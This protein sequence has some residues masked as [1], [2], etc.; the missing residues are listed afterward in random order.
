MARSGVITT[1]RQAQ[2]ANRQNTTLLDRLD[3]GPDPYPGNATN[4]V[5]PADTMRDAA[6]RIRDLER[7]VAYLAQLI[8]KAIKS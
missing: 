2:A 7:R 1:R 6:Q 8:D 4:T 3:H 5:C